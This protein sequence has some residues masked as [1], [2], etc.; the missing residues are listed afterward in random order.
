M[1]TSPKKRERADDDEVKD[2]TRT[3]YCPVSPSYA[4]AARKVLLA[5]I[6]DKF[7]AVNDYGY[8]PC[9]ATDRYNL[10][11]EHIKALRGSTPSSRVA[12]GIPGCVEEV[13]GDDGEL[14]DGDWSGPMWTHLDPK[15]VQ[16]YTNTHHCML[17]FAFEE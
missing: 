5:L 6:N 13:R 3:V 11:E 4:P 10:T 7:P 12:K 8:L 1:S 2:F 9:V 14:E 17:M 16:T 15:E